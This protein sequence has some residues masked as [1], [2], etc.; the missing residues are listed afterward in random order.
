MHKPIIIRRYQQW[1]GQQQKT[2]ISAHVANCGCNDIIFLQQPVNISDTISRMY[3]PYTILYTRISDVTSFPTWTLRQQR[4][5]DRAYPLD[6]F[7]TVKRGGGGERKGVG[8][9]APVVWPE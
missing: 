4:S 9:C 6:I 2:L 7:R 1:K 3:N 5:D 8:F